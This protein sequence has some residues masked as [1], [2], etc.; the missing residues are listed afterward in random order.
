MQ[1]YISG[2]QTQSNQRP[3]MPYYVAFLALLSVSF[4]QQ[5]QQQQQLQQRQRLQPALRATQCPY[6]NCTATAIHT[7]NCDTGMLC[8][9]DPHIRARSVFGEWLDRKGYRKKNRN[10]Y[11]RNLHNCSC[12]VHEWHI[13]RFTSSTNIWKVLFVS[14]FKHRCQHT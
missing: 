3:V 1:W 10:L 4:A 8:S 14:L 12:G 5:Q 13:C 2:G 9:V 7:F 11:K 6:P